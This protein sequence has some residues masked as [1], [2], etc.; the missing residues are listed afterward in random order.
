M[1][2]EEL[3]T[4]WRGARDKGSP[5]AWEGTQGTLVAGPTAS[6][7]PRVTLPPLW[8]RHQNHHSSYRGIRDES[9]LPASCLPPT[10]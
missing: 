7:V 9:N 2:A 6:Q 1:W 4:A 10:P 3:M 8:L 5:T